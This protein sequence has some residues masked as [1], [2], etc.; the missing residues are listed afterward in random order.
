MQRF[1]WALF[2]AISHSGCVFFG[3]GDSLESS[4][5]G[6]CGAPLSSAELEFGRLSAQG[7]GTGGLS[8][9]ALWGPY[10]HGDANY[11]PLMISDGTRYLY[12]FDYGTLKRID[13]QTQRSEILLGRTGDLRHLDGSFDFAR[14]EGVQAATV[15]G[16][17]I[18]ISEND[19]TES[20]LY[21]RDIDLS[22]RTVSTYYS[23]MGSPL[24][25]KVLGLA[26]DGTNLY[27]SS[28]TQHAIFKFSS[29]YPTLFAGTS[30]TSGSV[31]GDG[32]SSSFNTPQQ[33]IFIST[34]Q[35]GWTN[36]ALL[37]LDQG[38]SLVRQ[39][40]LTA[41]PYVSTLAGGG[42]TTNPTTSA[43][44]SEFALP[45]QFALSFIRY[46]NIPYAII[47]SSNATPAPGD[48]NN[49]FQLDLTSNSGYRF[50]GGGGE[51]LSTSALTDGYAQ[52]EA[53]YFRISEPTV[54]GEKLYFLDDHLALR[55]YDFGTGWVHTLF[56]RIRGRV[57]PSYG[58]FFN[59]R[60]FEALDNQVYFVEP[61]RNLLMNIDRNNKTLNIAAGMDLSSARMDGLGTGA[62]FLNPMGM[63]SD[64]SSNLYILDKNAGSAYI[65]RYDMNSQAVSTL[66]D[67][68]STS[69]PD[70][71]GHILY[72]PSRHSLIISHYGA[73]QEYQSFD[74]ATLFSYSTIAGES[75]YS[76]F[77][78]GFGTNA[79]F[80]SITDLSTDG[81]DTLFV[82]EGFPNCAIR[83]VQISTG[84]VSTLIGGPDACG[85]TL[86]SSS[87]ALEKP[88]YS[89]LRMHYQRGCLYFYDS[90]NFEVR[91]LNLASRKLETVWG[92]GE[93]SA[94]FPSEA[95][96]PG[97]DS[98]G[99][100]LGVFPDWAHD[101]FILPTVTGI[102]SS[103]FN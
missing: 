15:S 73:L 54:I 70:S 92:F 3:L 30:G 19:S 29:N 2:I 93:G 56:G 65:R 67:G 58:G 51:R 72:I 14:I 38:N 11:T 35:S 68:G 31:N 18:F 33:L 41:S 79:R 17:H 50:L 75:S 39:I 26:H 91:A 69:I 25:L 74:N 101:G 77:V 66:P 27:A 40:K 82:L 16:D 13:T 87:D 21:I 71:E 43:Y 9:T 55:E 6:P 34:S 12:L 47:S 28:A 10:R 62:E 59:P 103:H 20:T 53:T 76:G 84:E 83:S 49:L 37:V 22:T 24:G 86:F 60:D 5:L 1:G 46:N 45:E 44:S 98:V 81:E 96:R 85:S 97:Q 90:A 64:R 63:T 89:D 94:H 52:S 78:D 36:D 57:L 48:G 80:D 42:I 95:P 99:R 88:F 4:N 100:F 23:E 32:T 8:E 7:A 61:E 102:H